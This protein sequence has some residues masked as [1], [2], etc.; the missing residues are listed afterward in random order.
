VALP[1]LLEVA[2]GQGALAVMNEVAVGERVTVEPTLTCGHC[3]PC[4]HGA[5][6]LC[7]NLEFFGC[8]YRE[9]G[10]GK[11]PFLRGVSPRPELGY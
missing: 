8:G 3:K 11:T 9:G 5:E 2:S 10:T 1:T 4:R 6:N 7:E